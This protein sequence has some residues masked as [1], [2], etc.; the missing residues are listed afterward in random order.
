MAVKFANNVSTTLSAAINA[1]QTTISV[2]DAS[3]LPT[4]SSGDYIYLTID[5][6]TNSP[7]IE[8]V[9]VTGVSTNTLTV[10][11]GQDGTTASSFSNGTK[12]ELRVTAAALDDI[13]SAADT[14]SVSIDG[15]TMTGTLTAPT[16]IAGAYGASGAAGDGFRINST[17]IYGQVDSSDKIHISAVTGAI[18]SGAITSTGNSLFTGSGSSGNA[19]NVLRGSDSTSAFRVMNT[20][21]VLVSSNYFYVNA[22]QGAYF[23]GAIRARGSITNDGGNNLSISSGGS[24][25]TFNSK[26]FTSVGTISSGAITSSASVIASGNSN[27]FGNTTISNLTVTSVTASGSITASGNSNSFGHTTVGSLASGSITTSS[28]ITGSYSSNNGYVHKLTNSN[29]GTSAYTEFTVESGSQE[30]RIG[31]SQNYS[32]GQWDGSWVYAAAGDLF[33]KSGLG[34]VKIYAGDTVTPRWSFNSDGS[35]RQGDYNGNTFVDSSRNITAGT[36]S[37]GAITSSGFIRST[38]V[39]PGN[40]QPSTDEVRVSGY[41]LIGNRENLYITNANSAGLVQIGVGGAHNAN[42][43]LTVTNSTI[44]THGSSITSGSITVGPTSGG[45]G[46]LIRA[47]GA[48]S[49]DVTGSPSNVPLVLQATGSD[50]TF[51]GALNRYGRQV[52]AVNISGSADSNTQRGVIDFYTKT[53]GSFQ[54][55]LTLSNDDVIA[56]GDLTVDAKITVSGAGSSLAAPVYIAQQNTTGEGGEITLNGS[57]GNTSHTLDTVNGTFR[58]FDANGTFITGNSGYGLNSING[59]RVNGTLVIDSNKRLLVSDGSASAPYMTFAAD[60]NTGFYRPAADNI[61][62]AIGGVARAFMSGTQFNM[63]GNVTGHTLIADVGADTAVGVRIQRYSSSGR[64]Q[65]TYEDQSGNQIWRI[66]MTGP[67]SENFAFFD[68]S[69]NVLELDR[70]TNNASFYGDVTIGG[71]LILTGDINQYNVTDLD[72]ADKTITVNAGGSQTLSDG[73]GLIIDRGT[74]PD[75]SILWDETNDHLVFNTYVR[76]GDTVEGGGGDK[77]LLAKGTEADIWLTSTGGGAGTWRVMGATGNSTKLFRI[78]DHDAGVNRLTVDTS[79]NVAIGGNITSG[80]ITASGSSVFNPT[81]DMIVVN[82]PSTNT[83]LQTVMRV[84]TSAGGLFLTTNNAIIGKGAYYDGGWIATST[85]G[86]SIDFAG[87]NR[88]TFNTFSG[89]TVGGAAAYGSRAYIDSAGLNVTGTISSG[90]SLT[91]N[92]ANLI[93]A[94]SISG[95]GKLYFSGH[96]SASQ[97]NYFLKADNDT[98][99]KAVMF[100]NGSTRTSDGGANTFTIRNDGGPLRLGNSSYVTTIEGSSFTVP[101]VTSLSTISARADYNISTQGG[102]QLILYDNTTDTLNMRFGVDTAIGASGGASIQVTQSG[103]SN[104]RD[105]KL[106]PYGGKV[107]VNVSSGTSLSYNL[108]VGGTLYASHKATFDNAVVADSLHIRG[109]TNSAYTEGSMVGGISLWGSTG[110]T[111]SQIMF[112]PTSA[113]SPAL[114]NHGFCTDDYNTYFVMDTTNRGWVFRNATTD[115]NVASISNT[116]GAAFNN[117]IKIGTQT[118]VDSNR[119]LT[120]IGSISS[121]GITS[122]GNITS[123]GYI[124]AASYVEAGNYKVHAVEVIDTNRVLKNITRADFANFSVTGTSTVDPSVLRYANIGANPEGSHLS[125]PFFFNDLANFVA[126]GGTVTVSGLSGGATLTECFRANGRFASWNNGS[127]S[128]STMTITLTNLPH[129]LSYGGYIGIAFGNTS[130]CPSS[131]KIEVSTDGGS[132]WTTRL[133]SASAKEMYFTTTGTGGTAANAIRFTIGQAA[134]TTSIRCTHIWAYNYNSNGMEDYFLSKGGGT[135]YGTITSQGLT[136]SGHITMTSNGHSVNTRSVLAR[137]ANGLN[138]GATNGTTAIS[139]DNSSNVAMPYSLT[140]TG[141]ISGSS[142]MFASKGYF[143]TQSS[144]VSATVYV[145]SDGANNLQRWGSGDVNDSNSYRFRID[146][147]FKF[148]GNNGSVDKVTIHSDSGNIST[149]GNVITG[150][151]EIDVDDNTGVVLG[152]PRD[153]SWVVRS[154]VGGKANGVGDTWAIGHNGNSLYYGIGNGSSANS[155]ST[156]MIVNP[157]RVIYMENKLTVGDETYND[158]HLHVYSEDT[159]T[160]LVIDNRKNYGSGQG[161]ADRA[162]LIFSLS[163]NDTN[164]SAQ[165]RHFFRIEAGTLADTSSADGFAKFFVRQSGTPIEVMQFRN[166]GAVSISGDGSNYLAGM[167]RGAFELGSTS[168]SYKYTGGWASTMQAGILANTASNWEM[169]VHDAGDSVNS[170]ILYE[171]DGA[172]VAG[173]ITI[174]RNLGWGANDVIFGAGITTAALHPANTSVVSAMTGG[175]VDTQGGTITTGR[176]LFSGYND[177]GTDVYGF[178]NESNQFVLYNYT[179]SQYIMKVDGGSVVEFPTAVRFTHPSNYITSITNVDAGSTHFNNRGNRLLTSNGSN[180]LA[181]GRDPMFAFTANTTATTIGGSIGITMHNDQSTTNAM[182]PMIAF[183]AKSDSGNYNS[184]YA[185]ILGRKIG[186]GV[187]TNWN[188]GELWFYAMPQGVYASNYPTMQLVPDGLNINGSSGR[189]ADTRLYIHGHGSYDPGLFLTNDSQ[190]SSEGLE[191]WYDNSAGDSYITNKYST[192][193]LKFGTAT[194]SAVKSESNTRFEITSGGSLIFGGVD[195]SPFISETNEN[196]LNAGWNQNSDTSDMWINYRGYQDTTTKFRDF[197][198]GDGKNVEL[199][200]LDGSA[201]RWNWSNG[202]EQFN[203]KVHA[204]NDNANATWDDL[205]FQATDEWGDG[206]N[207]GVLGGTVGVMLRRP[208]VVWSSS[209]TAADIRFGRSGGVSTGSW[210]GVGTLASNEFSIHK[211]SRTGAILKFNGSNTWHF[212]TNNIALNAGIRFQDSSNRAISGNSLSNGYH[213]VEI[214]GNWDKFQVMGRVLDWS[215]SNLHFGDGYNGVDHSS[216]YFRIGTVDYMQVGGDFY[217]TGNV[218]AYYSD[219]RLKKN[220]ETIP[221]ALDIVKGIRGVYFEWNEK[222]EEVWSRKDGEKD[223]GLISQEVEAVFPMGVAVQAG[224]DKAKE[225]GYGDPDSEF[226]DPLHKGENEEEQYKTVKYDKMVAVAL[227]AI[228][229]QQEL[230]ESQ[231]AQIDELKTLV[232]NLLEK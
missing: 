22:S 200:H 113:G 26:N 38:I 188:A 107:G 64:A 155:L 195:H 41:G 59:Y 42:P 36:I 199:V 110:Q 82:E 191:I 45:S 58:I 206:Q 194:G 6:D 8:V 152:A 71:N 43:A 118:I 105:L 124:D 162:R 178:N 128:G 212:Q 67:A 141:T 73:A 112:K 119:N 39:D 23:T 54:K 143:G 189:N 129:G 4:L 163:E 109:D 7:T 136:T 182:S 77:Q 203:W 97:Y 150:N 101:S 35:I 92:G 80:A 201:R 227:Q 149:A 19:F 123:T 213:A 166:T 144:A 65:M 117:G 185:G 24:D 104:D 133:N 12:V 85:S 72:V 79:S 93:F 90:G 50:T 229:E 100:V 196:T 171:N 18:T 220:V 87:S 190:T 232:H 167:Q 62:F 148:I 28:I 157:Q 20:G 57:N 184:A 16:F 76:S 74:A 170:L 40:P 169:A 186:T 17:D 226:Y 56:R 198:F 121:A 3:G 91:V 81:S 11:R 37:S 132:T 218:I 9:K 53:S 27:S 99:R 139:I 225:K 180:W 84:G 68:G 221:N 138:L 61:G 147:N 14:E 207:Y 69:Q 154:G 205:E 158:G 98:G 208:H 15:D 197:R 10:V 214:T 179:D 210:Y 25:I 125:H 215:A 177:S 223:F 49:G 231:Q 120:N 160:D 111:T 63:T 153:F 187:D 209:D 34:H 135:V 88:I 122:S 33:L 51:F 95:D 134:N 130:W 2:A 13:S 193:S 78:Y 75:A 83:D 52:L 32:S 86:S 145:K 108:E 31:T 66:G 55:A 21:E 103:V 47:T 173:N 89:A 127:Y 161:T 181:D 222:S 94:S 156:Y 164:V 174:G 151:Q 211:D 146:Q 176:V 96:G 106:N 70:A 175:S 183:S 115:T 192:G 228:K 140:V 46:S 230:I 219:A 217:A 60:T 114:G 165:D 216:Y 137:D 131:C 159:N 5:T 172:N 48:F 44:N 224:A 202:T 116:G 102:A 204:N 29:T 1:T 30:L 168:R 126:R 142:S